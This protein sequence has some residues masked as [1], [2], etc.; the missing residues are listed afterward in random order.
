MKRTK[1]LNKPFLFPSRQDSIVEEREHEQRT[2]SCNASEQEKN[3]KQK[4]V[5]ANN[6]SATII[7]NVATINGVIVNVVLVGIAAINVVVPAV[8][9]QCFSQK[10]RIE[11]EDD[12]DVGDISML[13]S[14]L[15]NRNGSVKFIYTK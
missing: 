10:P 5:C 14:K 2:A 3:K 7:T 1:Y 11:W 8:D 13:C 12:V 4:I 15:R 6:I 9:L